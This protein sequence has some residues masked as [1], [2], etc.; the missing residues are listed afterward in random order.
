MSQFSEADRQRVLRM[1]EETVSAEKK[2]AP[3]VLAVFAE[4]A[5]LGID[6]LPV[7]INQ[8]DDQCGF[9]GEGGIRLGFSAISGKREQFINDLL[10]E[11]QKKGTFRAFQ[12]FCERNDLEAIP[13]EFFRKC[14]AGGVFDAIEPSRAALFAGYEKI[15]NAVRKAKADRASG[16]FGLFAMLP[17]A[18]PL[19]PISLPQVESWTEEEMI[20]RE[21]AALGF[22]FTEYQRLQHQSDDEGGSDAA[23]ADEPVETPAPQEAQPMPSPP[24]LSAEAVPEI[25]PDADAPNAQPP[26]SESADAAVEPAEEPAAPIQDEMPPIPD[27]LLEEP[28]VEDNIAIAP[29][30]PAAVEQP[31][32]TPLTLRLAANSTTTAMLLRLRELLELHPGAAPVV[33][34]FTENGQEIARIKA[35]DDYCVR[36][37]DELLAR[38]EGVIGQK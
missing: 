38:I 34:A 25:L 24:D 8:S 12:D 19:R 32:A 29:P 31:A 20:E 3:R 26:A 17:A 1:V 13:A 21:K 27:G 35:H 2:D 7:D 30:H 18:T 15:I 14:V 16:Q 28:P 6:A 23:A 22:S 10:A 11:R 5:Q 9:E 33:L 36:V 37:S 4:C